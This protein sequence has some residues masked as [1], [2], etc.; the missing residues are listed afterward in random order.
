MSELLQSAAPGRDLQCLP[1]T[2]RHVVPA[3]WADFNG[4]MN[5][6]YYLVVAARGTDRFLDLIGAGESYAAKGKGYFTVETHIR[7]LAEVHVDETL[8]VRTQLLAAEGKKLHLFHRLS[9]EDGAL[10]ATVETLLLHADLTSRRSS[11]P[12]PQVVHAIGH[13]LADHAA[14]SADGAGRFVGESRA[15]S[16]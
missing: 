3:D 4:H 2:G 5:E 11:L 6:A 1:T 9:R 15:A 14:M 12:D 16:R 8:T 7:Y 10:A 13:F